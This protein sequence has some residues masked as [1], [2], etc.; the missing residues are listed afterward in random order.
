MTRGF[1]DTDEFAPIFAVECDRDAA[2]TYA[3]NFGDHVLADMIE[4]VDV[5]PKADVVIGGPPCQ[6]FSPLNMVGVGL[7]RRTLWREYLRALRE[8]DPLIFVMEN[9]PELLKSGEY[10]AFQA[11]AEELGF[12]VEG[13]ILNAADYGVPQT[14]RRAIVIGSKLGDPVWPEQSHWALGKLPTG[15]EPWRTFRSAV[16]YPTP[17]PLEPDGVH[18]GTTPAIRGPSASSVTARSPVRARVVSTSPSAGP[19]SHRTAGCER[20]PAPPTSSGACGGIALPSPSAPSSTSRRKVDTHPS[21]H[22]PITVR[23]AARCQTLPDDFVLPED[24]PMMSIAKQI[25]NAVPCL[26]ARVLGDS[27]AGVLKRQAQ[28][29]AEELQAVPA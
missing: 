12:K 21:E 8:S 14:R 28:V 3:E 11:A 23:E 29:P 18:S 20:S 13:K 1:I 25:G 26:L 10:V 4:R 17:L 24:Q 6:G 15:G 9:V 22:R 5:F 19:T 16:T 7:E 27:V 2:A